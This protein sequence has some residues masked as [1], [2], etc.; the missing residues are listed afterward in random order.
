MC[1]KK[2][3]DRAY[4]C[5]TTVWSH[6]HHCQLEIVQT[7][8]YAGD[9]QTLDESHH[10]D[11]NG[12][13]QG[14]DTRWLLFFEDP[15]FC[16]FNHTRVSVNFMSHTGWNK[17]LDLELLGLAFNTPRWH[18]FFN[19]FCFHLTA[20][21]VLIIWQLPKNIIHVAPSGEFGLWVLDV[22]SKEQLCATCLLRRLFTLWQ[23]LNT[24]NRALSENLRVVED[25]SCYEITHIG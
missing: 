9:K 16:W 8:V 15:L 23:N 22:G 13:N 17:K 20:N 11:Q 4:A 19:L 10:F 6:W 5:I 12:Q 14:P 18:Y 1:A 21:F 3:T 7:A 2:Y 24:P 25:V